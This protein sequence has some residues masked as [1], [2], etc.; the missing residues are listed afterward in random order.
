MTTYI[1]LLRGINVG[2]HKPVAM[3]DLRELLAHLGFLDA[4]SLLQSGNLVFLGDARAGGELERLLETEAATRLG[5]DTCFFARTAEEWEAIVD[6][7]PFP[8]EA[9]RDPARLVVMFLKDAPA[10][11]GVD[12][13]QA[14]IA[15]PE[16]LRADG[17]QLYVVYP[18]GMG[19]SCLT[20][21]LIER[22]LGMR[23]TARNWNTVLGLRALSR[24]L[25][26]GTGPS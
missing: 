2:G 20:G 21:T 1:G 19:R 7:N 9:G 8:G 15:G 23:G 3:V 22:K 5:L 17:R 26:A 10:S 6:R 16:V 4:R 14:G 12:A 18:D 11:A 25:R 24:E 13:L